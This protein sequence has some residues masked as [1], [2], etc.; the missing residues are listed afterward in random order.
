MLI[1]SGRTN[2]FRSRREILP[3]KKDIILSEL[4]L[5]FKDNGFNVGI[6]RKE[7]RE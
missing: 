1:Y 6:S 5:K 7:G 4:L 3:F 2:S